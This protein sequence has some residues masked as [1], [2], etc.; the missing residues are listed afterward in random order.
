MALR[1]EGSI[2]GVQ[3][4][5]ITIEA[6]LYGRFWWGG[7]EPVSVTAMPRDAGTTVGGA[8]WQPQRLGPSRICLTA[9]H[10]PALPGYWDSALLPAGVRCATT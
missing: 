2:E 4:T 5:N 10:R 9:W 1:D 6:R 7:G 8:G 3:F